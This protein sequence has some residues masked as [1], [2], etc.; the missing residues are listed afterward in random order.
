MASE[1]AE[2]LWQVADTIGPETVAV[3]GGVDSVTL[4]VALHRHAPE[5][6]RIFHA[7]S[8]AVPP[9]A[10]ERVRAIARAEGWTVRI[11]RCGRI[12]GPG[13]SGQSGQS[14]FLLQ[15]Q[16]LCGDADPHRGRLAVGDER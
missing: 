14:L 5:H 12:P 13:L 11:R 16:P 7:I 1:I 10:T 9:E 2:R 3:S 8:P 6:T 4:A 15:V